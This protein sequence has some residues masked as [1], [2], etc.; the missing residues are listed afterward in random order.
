[1]NGQ[2]CVNFAWEEE[3]EEKRLAFPFCHF[4]FISN[5]LNRTRWWWW[6][7]KQES[8]RDIKEVCFLFFGFHIFIRKKNSDLYVQCLFKIFQEFMIGEKKVNFFLVRCPSSLLPHMLHMF[9][10]LLFFFFSNRSTVLFDLNCYTFGLFLQCHCYCYIC[11][12]FVHHC[13]KD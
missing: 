4:I 1:M 11:L 10:V 5:L 9:S 12:S 8:Q 6:I 7:N 2:W 13:V 3:E